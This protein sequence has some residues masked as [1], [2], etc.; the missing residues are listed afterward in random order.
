MVSVCVSL[1]VPGSCEDDSISE[2]CFICFFFGHFICF[3]PALYPGFLLDVSK[4]SNSNSP[5]KLQSHFRWVRVSV[6][7]EP[8]NGS[9]NTSDAV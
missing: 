9:V 4:D 8:L 3:S 1:D 5:V 7:G 2:P 6:P